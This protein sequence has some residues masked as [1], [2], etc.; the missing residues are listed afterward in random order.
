MAGMLL[1]FSVLAVYDSAKDVL[2]KL[3]GRVTKTRTM[4]TV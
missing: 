1:G 4:T 2:R 3:G